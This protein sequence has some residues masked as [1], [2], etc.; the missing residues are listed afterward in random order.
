MLQLGGTCIHVACAAECSLINLG[1]LLLFGWLDITWVP[2]SA[3]SMRQDALNQ[4]YT[5]VAGC[6]FLQARG[7][8]LGM[9]MTLCNGCEAC[10]E[11]GVD[12]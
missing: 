5:L 2:S 9:C 12:S 7:R 8:A 11:L 10:Y 4:K 3:Y 1:C 6:F